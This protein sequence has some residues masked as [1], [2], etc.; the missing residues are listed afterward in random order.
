MW[1][2]RDR[3]AHK[4]QNQVSNPRRHA[5][6]LICLIT[7]RYHL[8]YSEC[9]RKKSSDHSNR[10]L[11]IH[12]NESETTPLPLAFVLVTKERNSQNCQK[13]NIVEETLKF[14]VGENWPSE[15]VWYLS[16][17]SKRIPNEAVE[18]NLEP[19]RN[20]GEKVNMLIGNRQI[21][22]WCSKW[23]WTLKIYI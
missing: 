12:G 22:I 2:Q 6:K 15:C 10:T 19:L 1:S 20:H 21:Q 23:R 11:L 5:L 16:R 3:S 18:L 7:T 13:P 8:F 4:W 14:E 17:S 9:S